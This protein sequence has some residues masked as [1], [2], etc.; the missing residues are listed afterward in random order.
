[1][2]LLVALSVWPEMQLG[3]TVPF[4][5]SEK[6]A[7]L[8]N[9]KRFDEAVADYDLG[10]TITGLPADERARLQRGRGY[11][12]TEMRRLD[13]AEAAY[14]AALRLEPGDTRS[15]NELKYIAGLRAGQPAAPGGLSTQPPAAP[16]PAP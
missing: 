6:G 11:A 2:T 13:D 9:L 3:A 14:Q 15:L 8:N 7:A 16:A 10:L 12:L 4:L 5:I 1:M